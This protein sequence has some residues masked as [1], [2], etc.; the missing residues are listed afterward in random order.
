MS[1][2][3]Q[4]NNLSVEFPTR[5]GVLKALD[6]VSFSISPG[7]VLGVV[8][9]SGAGKSLTGAA[10]IGLLEPPGRI[11]GGEILLEGRRIDNLPEEQM[12]RVRGREIGAVFQDPLTSL[13]PLYTVGRQL[14]ETIL[15]HLPMTPRQARERAIELLA[16]T[17]IPAARERIDHY[18]HQ[19]SGGMRQRVVIALALAAE[20]KLV[21]AD[22]PTTALDVSIQAQIIELLKKLC[23][24]QGAAVM[25]ITHD[26]GVIA[27]TAD[28]VA[29][30]YAG[31]LAEI[32]PVADV[33]HRP[34]HPYTVGLMGS[35]PTLDGSNQRLVQ[36]D[37]SMPRLNAI[38]A[39]CAFN[40][41][42][43]R[44]LERCTRD[45]PELMSAG[46]SRAACW[47]LNEEVAA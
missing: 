31:R 37:G 1:A 24:E 42:C 26:M 30:M 17:G 11:S 8:G 15:T 38:P 32:G 35:I 9:E 10:I 43:E 47:L 44:K 28:R 46:T 34:S 2:L 23:R 14:V 5:R 7:E 29:V 45:R 6:D 27:E 21:V 20:P 22:E 19:F 41:R 12:R 33:I 25:L 4:V 3:L 18:P 36:I 13:N 16:A 40:P 39:G